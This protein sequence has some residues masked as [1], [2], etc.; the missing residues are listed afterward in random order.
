MV[1]GKTE[2]N[3]YSFCRSADECEMNMPEKYEMS[4]IYFDGKTRRYSCHGLRDTLAEGKHKDVKSCLDIELL[5]RQL[6]IEEYIERL[7]EVY[8]TKS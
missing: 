6:E 7:R 8:G 4:P 3:Y 5:N 2:E 1:K